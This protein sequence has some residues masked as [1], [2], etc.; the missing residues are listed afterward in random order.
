MEPAVFSRA[1]IDPPEGRAC[2]LGDSPISGVIGSLVS[3]S[4]APGVAK[5]PVPMRQR[6]GL[7]VA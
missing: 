7:L 5:T 4:L 2:G 3:S 1:G 6:Q